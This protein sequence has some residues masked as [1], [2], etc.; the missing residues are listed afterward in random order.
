M[1][2]VVDVRDVSRDVRAVIAALMSLEPLATPRALMLVATETTTCDALACVSARA[3]AVCGGA[4]ACRA[5]PVSAVQLA[6]GSA[7]LTLSRWEKRNV[8]TAAPPESCQTVSMLTCCHD[9]G[10]LRMHSTNDRSAAA[11]GADT[12]LAAVSEDDVSVMFV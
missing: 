3:S 5:R 7:P 11:T 9:C 1:D 8:V 6:V 2:V 12:T 10:T 4:R